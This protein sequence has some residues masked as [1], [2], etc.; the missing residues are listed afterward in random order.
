MRIHKKAYLNALVLTGWNLANSQTACQKQSNGNAP[1][2]VLNSHPWHSAAMP[3]VM[4]VKRYISVGLSALL[5]STSRAMR[6]PQSVG[7]VIGLA[8]R[9]FV[10]TAR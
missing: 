6:E 3:R 8:P 5:V 1:R 2:G 4:M 7:R 10:F 9:F